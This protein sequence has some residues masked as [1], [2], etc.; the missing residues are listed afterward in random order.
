MQKN[1]FKII[2]NS[3]ESSKLL[4]IIIL[5]LV[6]IFVMSQILTYYGINA[7]SYGIYMAFFLFLLVSILILP[8]Q[9]PTIS[10]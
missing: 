10:K 5:T 2:I 3:M 7:S 4:F 6:F 1:I 9:A 8:N